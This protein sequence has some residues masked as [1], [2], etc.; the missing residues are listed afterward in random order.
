[1]P[2]FYYFSYIIHVQPARINCE[3]SS[4]IF[5]T[6]NIVYHTKHPMKKETLN[7]YR[8]SSANS[9]W[10]ELVQHNFKNFRERECAYTIN[11]ERMEDSSEEVQYFI[12]QL[13]T[14]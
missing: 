2:N 13:N 3:I 9:L 14:L 5:S 7:L 12:G 4:P 8:A 6:E 11:V 10:N 1:M